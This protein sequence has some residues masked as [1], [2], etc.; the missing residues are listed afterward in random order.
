MNIFMSEIIETRKEE[1]LLTLLDKL[2]GWPVLM[3]DNWD[4]ES[5]DWIEV[6]FGKS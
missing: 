1:P 4:E 2:G 3:G 5:F 6:G